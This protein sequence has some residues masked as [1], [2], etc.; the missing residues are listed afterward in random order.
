MLFWLFQQWPRQRLWHKTQSSTKLRMTSAGVVSSRK[1]NQSKGLS[2]SI[3]RRHPCPK[4]SLAGLTSRW[5][6]SSA[7]TTQCSKDGATTIAALNPSVWPWNSL[8][9]QST[10][11]SPSYLA[12]EH[13]WACHSSLSWHHYTLKVWKTHAKDSTKR[14]RHPQILGLKTLVLTKK[15]WQS[16]ATMA[17]G[18]TRSFLKRRCHSTARKSWTE[19]ESC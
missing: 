17:T 5:A 19:S 8:A 18:P 4:R 13:L 6:W 1:S 10:S 3:L 11:T 2:R 14:L 12:L 9:S 15:S 16:P 7:S